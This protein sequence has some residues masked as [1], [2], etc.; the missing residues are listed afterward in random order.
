MR[1]SV[2][3]N[4]ALWCVKV[5]VALS[6]AR[7]RSAERQVRREW[8]HLPAHLQ[9]DLG[10]DNVPAVQDLQT[11]QR[12]ALRLVCRARQRHRWPTQS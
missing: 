10:L 7:E 9:R 2:L 11:R 5:D 8:A 4:L 3:L 12:Q 1:R 6:M